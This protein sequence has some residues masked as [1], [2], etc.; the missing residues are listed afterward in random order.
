MKRGWQSRGVSGG[1]EGAQDRDDLAALSFHTGRRGAGYS[2]LWT[3]DLN[4]DIKL[5]SAENS[6]MLMKLIQFYFRL[7]EHAH[8]VH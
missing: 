5:S 8:N 6:K 7:I 1:E 2:C 4:N 3:T